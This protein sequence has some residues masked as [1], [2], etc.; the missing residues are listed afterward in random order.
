MRKI[1]RVAAWLAVAVCG[2]V[3][4]YAASTQGVHKIQVAIQPDPT[5]GLT[6]EQRNVANRLLADNKPGSVKHLY[7]IA[8]KS[9]QVLIYSTVAGKVTSSSKRLNPGFT[10]V[11]YSCGKDST[12]YEGT[13][14]RV[15]SESKLT[16]EI[17]QDDGAYG[18]SVP[19]IFWWD[20]HG[21]YHQHFFTDGQV[22]QISDQPL[23]VRSVVLNF[24]KT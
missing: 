16:T 24:E 14:T 6:P 11:S 3:A 10:I 17:L 19:Y 8:P 20:A 15:G 1:A 21:R 22:I 13:R 12:C 23:A 5:D 4:V 18:S 9:G 2:S 7:V